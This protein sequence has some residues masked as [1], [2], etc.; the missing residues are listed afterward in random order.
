M[1]FRLVPNFLVMT[2]LENLP[3]GRGDHIHPESF[4]T[5]QA[6]QDEYDP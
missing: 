1:T 6:G 2:P 3:A 5:S 4:Y